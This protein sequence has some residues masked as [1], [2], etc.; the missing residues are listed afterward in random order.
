M[1]EL[2]PSLLAI[3][4]LGALIYANTLQAP[5]YFDDQGSIVKNTA[6]RIDG[7][8]WKQLYQAATS[9]PTP[10]RVVANLSFALNYY[11]QGYTVRGYHLVN[12]GIHLLN[13]CLVFVF[14][15]LTL[16]LIQ[17][18]P[19]QAERRQPPRVRYAIALLAALIFVA[20]P[21]QVQSVTYIVQRMT[22][23]ATL[24]Y[25]C[26]LVGYILG[27]MA[28]NGWLRAGLW[29]TALCS[30]LLAL[31]SKEIAALL[32]FTI[33]LYELYF[34]Q[35][36]RLRYKWRGLSLLV[37]GLMSFVAL[38]LVWL[39][40]DPWH[41]I[42][43]SYAHRDFTLGQRVL[44]EFRVI[45]MYLGLLLAPLPSRL[46]LLHEIPVS[47]SLFDPITT[48][49][50]L[51][52][53]LA[54]FG[55]AL[56]TAR[57][58]RLLSF[59][60]LWFF[61]HLAIESS[62]I[63]LELAYEHRLYLPDVGFSLV[64]AWAIVTLPRVSALLRATA[65]TLLVAALSLMTWQRNNTWREPV[66]FWSDIVAKYPDSYRGHVNLANA[67]SE[68]G[69]YQAALE[70][71]RRAL[72]LHPEDALVYLNT[73]M[74]LLHLQQPGRALKYLSISARSARDLPEA[75]LAYAIGLQ[76][77]GRP[78]EALVYYRDA[79]RLAPDDARVM[80]GIGE[81]L[82][83]VGRTDLALR[84]FRRALLLAP[85]DKE[86]SRNLARARSS[87]PEQTTGP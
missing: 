40:A 72:R 74:T 11:L 55:T 86:A 59:C 79:L 26:A 66:G 44:T 39:G 81:S 34:F 56:M 70:H 50:S 64:L 42:Q 77:A 45:I 17:G 7:L 19:S 83:L 25:L 29:L 67:L 14:A 49:L 73:G 12:I 65:A 33:L 71:D 16:H 35:D 20:H 31:G 84:Y 5:F 41:Y 8:E 38:T 78:N 46:S 57:R 24:F 60:I 10:N 27:R 62:V 68:A 58:F 85:G 48:L 82:L 47:Q 69:Q 18:L 22:S 76:R 43:A 61:G 15:L 53:L 54:L 52:A 13:A 80:N 21:I 1:R 6:I 3:L 37:L 51:I 28:K 9:G 4:V 63:G 30:W 23:L 87:L 2:T 36:L 75:Q 32:P